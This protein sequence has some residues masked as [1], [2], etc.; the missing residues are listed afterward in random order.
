MTEIGRISRIEGS[1]V[2]IKGGE[3]GSCF[4]CMNQECK[5]NQRVFTAENSYN[6]PLA[7]GQVVETE[8][9][10]RSSIFQAAAAILPP[11]L[12]FIAAF[13]L[14]GLLVPGSGDGAR[15]AAGV[16]GMFLVSFIVYLIRK[17]LIPAAMPRITRIL[18]ESDAVSIRHCAIH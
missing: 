11:A 16:L 3:I 12:G 17:H 10:A 1:A 13:M 4:G 2:T 14:T 18:D 9:P 7:A 15:A 8:T 6:L 5:S